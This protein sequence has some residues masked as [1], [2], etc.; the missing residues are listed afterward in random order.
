MTSL[1]EK[2]RIKLHTIVDQALDARSLTLYDQYVRDVEAYGRQVEESAARMVAGFQANKRRLA[3]YEAEERALDRRVDEQILAG[4]QEGARI[5]QGDLVAKREL[6]ATTRAQIA[7][8]EADHQRLLAGR[9][10][11]QER[12]QLMRGE[13]P[14]VEG[15]LA[16]IRAGE[17]MEQVEL[18]LG[19][20][21][22]LGHE[23]RIGEIAAGIQRR[24]DEAQVRWEAAAVRMGID[25][26]TAEVERSQIDDQLAERMRRL[27]LGEEE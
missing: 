21:A 19:G 26:A 17:L 27:G 6:I 16:A 11:T 13:R 5:L 12:L 1:L 4:S 23:S 14:A 8:Q 15:L 20:L 22:R 10:E 2:I 18:T 9:Q 3:E 7:N 25:R 24:F